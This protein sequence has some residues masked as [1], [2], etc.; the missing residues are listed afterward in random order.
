MFM[1]IDLLAGRSLESLPHASP[2][3]M[4][5]LMS[6]YPYH[7]GM[8]ALSSTLPSM[9]SAASFA[10]SSRAFLIRAG[11]GVGFYLL[12]FPS[13]LNASGWATGRGE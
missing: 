9:V 11:G 2:L 5:Y 1:P 12:G 4:G 8:S 3:N 6:P 7:N 10:S 13:H